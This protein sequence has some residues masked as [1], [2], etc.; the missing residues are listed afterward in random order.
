M[1]NAL[2]LNHN[3]DKYFPPFLFLLAIILHAF[4]L[5]LPDT[6]FMNWYFTDDAFYYF[7]VARNI[8]SGNGIS[9]D[10]ISLA[11]GFHPLWMLVCIPIFTL[12]QVN[13]FLPLKIL[14]MVSVLLTC[15]GSLLLFKMIR[16]VL[17]APFAI[18]G[19]VVWV[20]YWTVHQTVTQSGMEAGLNGFLMIALLFAY[21]KSHHQPVTMRNL[22]TLGLLA[23]LV[24]LSRLDNIFLVFFFGLWVIFRNTRMRFLVFA[25]VLS[26]FFSVFASI[27]LRV[28]VTQSLTFIHSTYFVIALS[29]ILRML[30][31]LLFGLYD[32]PGT[33][34]RAATVLR[35]FAGAGTASALIYALVTLFLRIGW[36]DGFPRSVFV[37]DIAFM[38]LSILLTRCI[39]MPRKM[40]TPN[41]ECMPRNLWKQWLLRGIL[42]FTPVLILFSIYITWHWLTFD[43]AMPVSGQIKQWWG[44]LPNTIYGHP[45]QTLKDVLGLQSTFCASQS[46]GGAWALAFSTI[47]APFHLV[48]RV[49]P[50]PVGLGCSYLTIPLLLLYIGSLAWLIRRNLKLFGKSVEHFSLPVLLAVG[51]LQPFYY[52]ASGYL[53]TRE[54]YW[55]VQI[56]A[57]I[58]CTVI[59]LA[60]LRELLIRRDTMRK[61]FTGVIYFSSVLV[62]A[63][64]AWNLL[65]VF[66]PAQTSSNVIDPSVPF[67]EENTEPGAKIGITGGGVTAYFITDR[68]IV[69][70]DGL[71]NSTEYFESMQ[72]GNTARFF[73]K[74]GLNYVFGNEMVLLDSDPYRWFFTGRLNPLQTID[75][76]TLYEY[77]P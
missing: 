60:S 4:L 48:N 55:L 27:I 37:Y 8:T 34:T 5:F 6:T 63:S 14:L 22:L 25:D 42:F 13:P 17:A 74:I 28:G 64:F 57:T 15:F 1:K 61:I 58:L 20:F 71:M 10:G 2:Q 16:A 7:Q 68:T 41:P 26:I 77:L 67:L 12:A 44:T 76:E 75:Q 56:L 38:L 36:L 3:I 52:H 51:I 19:S 18:L 73:D 50:P 49:L 54:W 45:H 21:S 32:P 65:K 29:I 39:L 40:E 62:L 69:N 46:S 72:T 43:T 11:S 31:N 35:C 53:H 24:L 66:P 30:I 33:H 70:L 47:L 9:F 23:G 59:L